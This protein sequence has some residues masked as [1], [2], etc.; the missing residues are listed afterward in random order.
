MKS[1]VSSAGVAG[2]VGCWTHAYTGQGE[3]VEFVVECVAGCWAI[4]VAMLEA[5]GIFV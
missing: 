3:L 1:K 2:G 5:V 4:L